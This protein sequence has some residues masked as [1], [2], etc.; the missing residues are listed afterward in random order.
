MKFEWDEV[1]NRSNIRKHGFDLADAQE[2]FSGNAP[3]FVTLDCRHEYGEERWKGVGMLGQVAVVVVVFTEPDND[4][5]RVISLRKADAR[6]R[7]E[8]ETE[9]KNRLAEG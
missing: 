4:T 6:E 1:K 3:L 7:K 9:I 2:L 8:Y 5:I